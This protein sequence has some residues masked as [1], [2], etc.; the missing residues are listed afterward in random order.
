MT[1]Y[2]VSETDEL[3]KLHES[4]FWY[5]QSLVSTMLLGSD[6]FLILL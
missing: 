3:L 5:A 2:L 1:I 4:Y 6:A